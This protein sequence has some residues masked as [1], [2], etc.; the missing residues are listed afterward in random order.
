MYNLYKHKVE[1]QYIIRF[2][3]NIIQLSINDID[4]HLL[5]IKIISLLVHSLKEIPKQLMGVVDN[6]STYSLS[7]L[8]A[9]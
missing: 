6:Q 5:S 1:L 2:R 4:E 9:M 3:C 8:N 7:Q